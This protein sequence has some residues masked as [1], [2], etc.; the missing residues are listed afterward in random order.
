MENVKIK[1]L[2]LSKYLKLMLRKNRYDNWY[3]SKFFSEEYNVHP[4]TVTE[5]FQNL[6]LLGYVEYKK[7]KGIKLTNFGLRE[8]LNLMRK[9]R[10]LEYFFANEL[11]L[12]NEE[13][14]KEAEKIDFIISDKIID[15]L[16]IK[17]SYPKTCP[18][19]H[20]IHYD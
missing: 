10:I 17:F 3:S 20:D 15:K 4:S 14:C 16:C 1:Q 7:Y 18:C 2:T 19:G 11:G 12:S 5:Q 6:S 13:A 9:H 8:G